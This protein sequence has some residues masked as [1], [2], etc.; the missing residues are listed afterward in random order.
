MTGTDVFSNQ[1]T[2]YIYDM[3]IYLM[4]WPGWQC[5]ASHGLTAATRIN[6]ISVTIFI[7]RPATNQR[8]TLSK[9]TRRDIRVLFRLPL[10]YG[11]LDIYPTFS[12]PRT[13]NSETHV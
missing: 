7:H 4:Q 12:A 13:G 6:L 2:P 11:G 3:G 9:K 10:Q 1:S 5:L 8:K